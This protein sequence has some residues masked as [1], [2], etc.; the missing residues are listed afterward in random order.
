MNSRFK[1]TELNGLRKNVKGRDMPPAT[2]TRPFRQHQSTFSMS[3]GLGRNRSTYRKARSIPGVADP[4]CFVMTVPCTQKAGDLEWQSLGGA[5]T[6]YVGID[7]H[8]TT[9]RAAYGLKQR[10][11]A[12]AQ[13]AVLRANRAVYAGGLLE[14]YCSCLMV[15]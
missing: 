8:L 1:I 3:F 10:W 11:Q 4:I 13:E 7:L 6:P 2:Q 15:A 14:A 12:A 9:G 5:L